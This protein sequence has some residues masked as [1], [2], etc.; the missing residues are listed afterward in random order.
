[1]AGNSVSVP[2]IKAIAGEMIKAL[3][4]Q[5]AFKAQLTQLRLPELEV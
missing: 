5:K 1:V 3:Q 4:A 2:V